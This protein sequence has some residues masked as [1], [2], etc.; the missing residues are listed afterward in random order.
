MSDAPGGRKELGTKDAAES[1]QSPLYQKVKAFVVRSIDEGTWAPHGRI[2]SE[3]DLVDRLGVSRM[4]V[5]R[6]LRELTA[7]GRLYRVQGVGT[8]VAAPKPET[9]FLEVRNIADE[10]RS[11]GGEHSCEVLCLRA[12]PAEEEIAAGMGLAVGTEVY[13]AVLLHKDRGLPI[14]HAD[15]YV[16]PAVAP[17][18]LAQDFTRVTPNE[19]LFAVAPATEAEHVVEA[20]MPDAR[21]R[22]LLQMPEGE[23]CVVLHRTTWVGSTVATRNRLTYPASRFRIRGRFR[24]NPDRGRGTP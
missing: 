8:F 23:P 20:V 4:T 5:H 6:A 16:N 18:F 1:R 13:H 7:E 11:R 9:A 2:P 14:Q 19:Y 24:V 3:H 12:E 10:I 22:K 21:T 15:R 17:G